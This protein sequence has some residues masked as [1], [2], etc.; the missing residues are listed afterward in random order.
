MAKP[1]DAAM[2]GPGSPPARVGGARIDHIEVP[3]WLMI[4]LI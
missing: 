4:L 2:A 3:T 1:D